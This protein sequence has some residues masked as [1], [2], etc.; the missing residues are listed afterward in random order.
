[1]ITILRILLFGV[2]VVSGIVYAEEGMLPLSW[3]IRERTVMGGLSLVNPDGSLFSVKAPL[4]LQRTEE[5]RLLVNLQGTQITLRP[6]EK[7]VVQRQELTSQRRAIG[8]ALRLGDTVIA[9]DYREAYIYR[10]EMENGRIFLGAQHRLTDAVS[11]YGGCSNRG[12]TTGATWHLRQGEVGVA[13]MQK[14]SGDFRN[15]YGFK[16]EGRDVIVANFRL[17]F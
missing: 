9:A 11:M 10:G 1:M 6:A 17:T 8:A 5:Q 3:G 14:Q 12:C 15:T 16:E 13:Y 7:A 2:V 4:F